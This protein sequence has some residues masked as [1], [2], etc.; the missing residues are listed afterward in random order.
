MT[1]I[2]EV[3]NTHQERLELY[4]K[5]H[6]DLHC[7]TLQISLSEIQVYCILVI[8][9]KTSSN[10]TNEYLSTKHEYLFY[11]NPVMSALHTCFHRTIH[12]MEALLRLCVKSRSKYSFWNFGMS[13]MNSHNI[14]DLCWQ[15]HLVLGCN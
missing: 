2:K 12:S 4:W 5:Y 15:L 9:K 14:L 10:W 3:I 8:Y 13:R 7:W 6:L 1:L 11:N